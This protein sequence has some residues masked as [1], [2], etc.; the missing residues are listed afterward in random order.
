MMVQ[1]WKNRIKRDYSWAGTSL[2]NIDYSCGLVWFGLVVEM[3]IANQ[4]KLRGSM[5]KSSE[6][7]RT[8]CDFLRFWIGL[9]CGFSIGLVQF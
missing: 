8:K 9:I 3:Q 1:Q 2:S 5:Q 4:T 7:I 6:F